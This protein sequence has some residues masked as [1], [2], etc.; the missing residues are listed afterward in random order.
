[1]G[2]TPA[3]PRPA[4]RACWAGALGGVSV[5]GAVDRVAVEARRDHGRQADADAHAL[6][7]VAALEVAG[8]LVQLRQRPALARTG[9]S[10]STSRSVRSNSAAIRSPSASRPSPVSAETSCAVGM[11][12]RELA[13]ALLVEHVGLVEHEQARLVAGADLLEHVLDR[14]RHLDELLLGGAGVDHV[15]DQVGPVGLLE[16]RAERVDQLVRA[17][18]G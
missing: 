11:A 9:T 5:A 6:R 7:R 12:E 3:A 8:D 1:M 4:L 2:L 16:R 10:S 13:P 15:Q 18:C 17:A 14:A